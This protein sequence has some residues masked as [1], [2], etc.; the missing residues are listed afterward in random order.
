MRS[1]MGLLPDQ[2]RKRYPDTEFEFTKPGESGQDVKVTGGRHPSD[3]PGSDWPK[4]VDRGDFKP[5]TSGG[6]KTFRSDQR[7]K[8]SEP[9][10]NIPYDPASG[11]LK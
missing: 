6:R 10:H 1:C 8:W 4:S 7:N 11:T 3:Y 2:L 9:T 5:D